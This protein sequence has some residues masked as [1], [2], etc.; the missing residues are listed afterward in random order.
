MK[1]PWPSNRGLITDFSRSDRYRAQSHGKIVGGAHTYSKGDDQFPERAPAA[2]ARGKHGR[3]WDLD[4]NEYVDCALG[5]G[6]VSLG[7]AYEP[8]LTAVREQLE[9]GAA[10]ARPASI[11]LELASELLVAMPGMERVKFAKNGSNVTTAAVKLARAFTGRELVAFPADHSFYSFDDWF[12]G[13]T[14]MPSGAPDAYRRLAVTYKSTDPASLEALFER[15]PGQIACVISEPENVIPIDPSVIREV[16][17][18]AKR[19]GAVFIVDEMITGFR[20]DFPGAY[21]LHGLEPDL[22][23]WG[24]AIGNGFSFCALTGRAEIMDLGGIKHASRPRV[25]LLSSTHGGEAHSLAAALTVLREYRDK[26]V[27][28]THRRLVARVADGM[29]AALAAHGLAQYIALHATPWRV[30]LVFSDAEGLVS[31]PLRTLFLQEMIARGVLFQGLYLPCYTHTDEDVVQILSA[32]ADACAVYGQALSQ[33]W[34]DMLVGEPTR[35]VFRKYNGCTM[36][37]AVQPCPNEAQC[38]SRG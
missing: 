29:R 17:Q 14:A 27:I 32:F 11:E 30:L 19:H 6:A 13:N 1:E 21:V 28:D 38:R 2:I 18:I 16:Q 12:I 26:P 34:R 7:H 10:F 3:V 5:L 24:K 22:V 25:F 8:V 36:S 9:L 33:G 20:A 4:G 31:S 15:H 35:P 37:C 23:T